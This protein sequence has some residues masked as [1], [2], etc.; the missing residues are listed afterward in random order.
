M[1]KIGLLFLFLIVLILFLFLLKTVS[2]IEEWNFLS[3]R[4]TVLL[5]AVIWVLMV[6]R[7][8]RFDRICI[9]L[10]IV[11]NILLIGNMLLY[12]LS[13]DE[14]LI[15][16]G[17][18]V[19]GTITIFDPQTIEQ[20]KY[21]D[22]YINDTAANFIWFTAPLFSLFYTLVFYVFVRIFSKIKKYRHRVHTHPGE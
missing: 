16:Y 1:K 11:L 10:F 13:L 5:F 15:S 7:Y 18:I 8:L 20:E 2:L 19:D 12:R 3:H 9:L 22:N 6:K 17:M 21:F 4:Y 14:K